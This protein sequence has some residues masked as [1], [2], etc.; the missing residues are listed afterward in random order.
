MK[1]ITDTA[2]E[3]HQRLIVSDF[4]ARL[5]AE[6]KALSEKPMGAFG[7]TLENRGSEGLVTLLPQVGD[8]GRINQIL[9]EG[10][11][12]LHALALFFAELESMSPIGHC[13]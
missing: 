4:E 1:K 2:K 10:E 12:R 13:V 3:T 7:V 9:S 11:Q 8:E 5:N 6:Y